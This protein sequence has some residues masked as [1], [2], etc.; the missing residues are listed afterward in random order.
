M[1]MKLACEKLNCPVSAN[2]ELRSIIFH[3]F[4]SKNMNH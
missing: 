1:H 3:N 2:I 4:N